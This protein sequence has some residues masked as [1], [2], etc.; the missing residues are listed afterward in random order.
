M[1]YIG[2]KEYIYFEFSSGSFERYRRSKMRRHKTSI[3]GPNESEKVMGG[4]AGTE[5][6]R[7][8]YVQKYDLRL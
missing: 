2:K 6:M 8:I 5:S 4:K 1:L 3:D 7:R